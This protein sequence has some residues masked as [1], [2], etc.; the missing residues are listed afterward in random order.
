MKILLLAFDYISIEPSSCFFHFQIVGFRVAF[1]LCS[2][3]ANNFGAKF[4]ELL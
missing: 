2:N 4:V 1:Q 3:M